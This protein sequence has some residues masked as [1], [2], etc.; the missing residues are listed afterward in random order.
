MRWTQNLNQYGAIHFHDDD[1]EDCKWPVTFEW[2]VPSGT[3]SGNYAL[4]LE[5][6]G[7][8]DNIPFFVV[9]PKGKPTAK[10]AVL[11]S[12]FTYT[13]YGNHLRPEWQGD[14][15]W[16]DA[17]RQQTK[18]WGAYPHHPGDS[19]EFGLSTYNYH[20]DASGI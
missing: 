7:E 20:T 17:W 13:V 18:A 15:K 11:V 1:I 12:T 8:Q 10:I 9:P 16:V 2:M 14:P 6:G 5:A 3:R 19:P 4:L